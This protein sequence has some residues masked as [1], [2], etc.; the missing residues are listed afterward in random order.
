[1][2]AQNILIRV[3]SPEGTKRVLLSGEDSTRTLY[4]KIQSEFGLD[5]F[6]FRLY[7]DR[8]RTRELV[9]TGRKTLLSFG[10]KH[11][12][13]V[14]MA[15]G[16]TCRI[17]APPLGPSSAISDEKIAAVGDLKNSESSEA[18]KYASGAPDAVSVVE[19]DVDIELA[20][21]DGKI[22]RPRDPS[23][24]RHNANSKCAHCFPLDPWDE[25]SFH[26]FFS[27]C[28]FNVWPRIVIEPV[29]L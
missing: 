16:D 13:M 19:D 17:T 28:R 4:E 14:F 25:G 11:G 29:Y 22:Q 10:L 23:H 18:S 15:C 24:C 3:Q 2:A 20:K 12:D 5:T 1:M 21:R 27:M 7:I 8:A 6:D 26:F 9:S